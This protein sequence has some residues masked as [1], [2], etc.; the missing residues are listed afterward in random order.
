MRPAAIM[1][2]IAVC[3]ASASSSPSSLLRHRITSCVENAA[4][5]AMI[6]SAASWTLGVSVWPF[7]FRSSSSFFSA[8]C[9]AMRFAHSVNFCPYGA[10]KRRLAS[11]ARWPSVVKW[12]SWN[13]PRRSVW[14]DKSSPTSRLNSIC[15]LKRCRKMGLDTR[16]LNFSLRQCESMNSEMPASAWQWPDVARN[17]TDRLG[18]CF[19]NSSAS[20]RSAATLVACSAPGDRPGTTDMES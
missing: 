15:S 12:P 17:S 11:A 14:L 5:S 13:A 19:L 18:W 2:S 1:A 7:V 9:P 16:P 6:V 4:N 10:K 3:T 8:R 20:S